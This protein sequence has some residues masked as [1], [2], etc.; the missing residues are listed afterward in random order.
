MSRQGV[1]LL[2]IAIAATAFTWLASGTELG[3]KLEFGISDAAVQLLNRQ[4][5]SDIVIIGIDARSLAELQE[6]PWPRRYHATLLNRLEPALPEQVF[7]DIDF[8][9]YANVSDDEALE[10]AIESWPDDTIVLPAFVQQA[11]LAD[12]TRLL[13]APLPAFAR[14]AR[15]ASVNLEPGIDGMVRDLPAFGGT[16]QQKLPTIATLIA[17]D[18]IETE[19]RVSIDFSIDPASF[20]YLSYVDV[21]NNRVAAQH[22]ANKTIFVGATAIELGD[23]VPVP[24]HQ[25]LPGVIVQALALESARQGLLVRLPHGVEW[26]LA[27]AWAL[28]LGALFRHLTWRK[29]LLALGGALSLA[30]GASI[31]ACQ[32]LNTAGAYLPFA[33]TAATSYLLVTLWSLESETLRALAYAIGFRKRDA[34]LKSIVLSTSDCIICI[35][36]NGLIKTANPAADSLFGVNPRSLVGQS[37]LRFVPLL[38]VDPHSGAARR[39]DEMSD[40]VIEATA[41]PESGECLPVELSVS[42]V[43]LNDEQLYTA[44]IRDIS[45]RHAQQKQLQFQATHDPLT[46]LPN[47]PAMAAYLDSALVKRDRDHPFALMMIDLNR[48]KEVND[49]LG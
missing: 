9:S 49:T 18:L 42:K 23:M 24:I 25:S 16:E 7:I 4:V 40:K 3:R 47:R 44:I 8:S 17:G 31:T 11:S 30:G 27:F 13:T 34:L 19:D 20:E 32:L 48:F 39:L 28:L 10:S 36:E 41:E 46:A 37:I 5:E 14:H 43:Q 38:L 45:E 6:W 21:L 33:L 12:T 15:L 29:S 35:D 2:Q 22:F 1:S 26:L